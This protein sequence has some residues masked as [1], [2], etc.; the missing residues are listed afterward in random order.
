ML[1]G[2]LR[3]Q[4]ERRALHEKVDHQRT[5]RNLGSDV[6]KNA[7]S[8]ETE[9]PLPQQIPS[10][11]RIVVSSTLDSTSRL[12]SNQTSAAKRISTLASPR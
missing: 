11:C 3:A 5:D 6:Q 7:Q 12:R 4:T 10:E 8:A 2:L 9:P 1:T